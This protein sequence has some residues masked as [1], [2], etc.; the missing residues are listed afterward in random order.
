[1]TQAQP[2]ALAAS[3]ALPASVMLVAAVSPFERPLPGSLLG[4]TLTS[5]ELTIVIALGI[6]AATWWRM[7]VSSV[8]RTPITLP[9]IALCGCALIAAIAATEFSDDAIRVAA[10]HAT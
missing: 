10:R 3:R 5:V 9:L 2:R 7:P 8:W 1:M 4:L 6:A